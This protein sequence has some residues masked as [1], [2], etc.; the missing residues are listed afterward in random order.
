MP[1]KRVNY[2]AFR[3]KKKTIFISFLFCNLCFVYSFSDTPTYTTFPRFN[4]KTSTAR[5]K[6][7]IWKNIP[8]YCVDLFDGPTPSLP[9]NRKMSDV[10]QSKHILYRIRNVKMSQNAMLIFEIKISSLYS[11]HHQLDLNILVGQNPNSLSYILY[12][13]NVLLLLLFAI[14]I[15]QKRLSYYLI[16]IVLSGRLS[17]LIAISQKS[18]D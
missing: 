1:A 4:F 3:N 6:S 14:W 13:H 9:V 7:T 16:A 5:V 15:F 18:L 12:N 11:H 17:W 10:V 2:T 8:P